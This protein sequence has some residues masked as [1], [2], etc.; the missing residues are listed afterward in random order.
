MAVTRR[1]VATLL[2]LSLILGLGWLV[3]APALG[4]P[5]LLDDIGNLSGLSRVEDLQS[6]LLFIFSGDAGP[7]GRP[8]ALASFAVQA[9][10][11]GGPARPFLAVNVLIHV[12]NAA[13]LFWVLYR[14]SV[15]SGVP[16]NVRVF[17]AGAS[18]A[19][20]LFM[21]LLASASLMVVQRMTTLSATFV[22]LGLAGYLH[23]R[24]GIE[25][26]PRR[27]IVLMSASLVMGTILAAFT[28]ESGA[29]LPVYVLVLESTLLRRPSAAGREWFFWKTVFLVLPTAAIAGY[30]A[31]RIP[32][33]MPLVLARDFT[34][35]ER[36]ITEA[37]VLWQYLFNAFLPRPGSFGPFHDDVPISRTLLEPLTIAATGAWIVVL[38]LALR[39][40]RRQPLFALAVL[41]FSAGHLIESTVVPLEI[42]FEHRNYLPVIGPLFALF[43]ALPRVP[44]EYRR[45]A[46]AGAGAWILINAAFLF[47]L[48]S[49]WGNPPLAVRYWHGH[50]PESVRAATTFAE[51]VLKEEGAKPALRTLEQIANAEP[52]S[53]YVLIP[54]LSLSCTIAPDANLEPQ[55]EKVAG[56]LGN[57]DFSQTVSTMLSDLYTTALR[58]DCHGVDAAVVQELAQALLRNPRYAKNPAYNR[59]HHELMARMLRDRGEFERTLEHLRAARGIG[60]D[61]KLNMMFVTTYADARRFDAAKEYIAQARGEPPLRPW[62]RFVWQRGLDELETYIAMVERSTNSPTG[63]GAQVQ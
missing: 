60:R 49:L 28:K 15:S 42:Y 9:D 7:L 50:S 37:R 24:G 26:S 58:T 52:G 33:D 32:Y 54:A 19:A 3:Y 5:L 20:W 13:L 31:S 8:I 25:Q 51:Y 14:L 55:V 18:A 4:G 21:P 30:V 22:L 41:W 43:A 63:S 23:W 2:V 11:W 39:W 27:S 16:E 10:A 57:V 44:G 59:L 35:W 34:G 62:K 46:V 56:L 17:V 6:A 53:A 48:T 61:V 47:S 45:L 40:R 1:G 29:L 38:G 12:A 36:L